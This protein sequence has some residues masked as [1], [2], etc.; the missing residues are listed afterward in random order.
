MTTIVE[1]GASTALLL[2]CLLRCYPKAAACLFRR[3]F[4]DLL[5]VECVCC[6]PK[7]LGT[8]EAARLSSPMVVSKKLRVLNVMRLPGAKVLPPAKADDWSIRAKIVT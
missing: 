8:L 1:D 7:V 5:L 6:V 2:V 4:S 3:R